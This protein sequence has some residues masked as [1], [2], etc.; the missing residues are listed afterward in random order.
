MIGICAYIKHYQ[1][2]L[3]AIRSILYTKNTHIF[4]F[5]IAIYFGAD[6][7]NVSGDIELELSVV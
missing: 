2:S 7:L 3:N 1:Y 6:F 4:V 5:S